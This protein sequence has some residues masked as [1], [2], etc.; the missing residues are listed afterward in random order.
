M[1]VIKKDAFFAIVFSS[2][3]QKPMDFLF[4]HVASDQE[5]TEK[6]EQDQRIP[7]KS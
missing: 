7:L 6:P 1:C 2:T 5:F 4:D 3:C